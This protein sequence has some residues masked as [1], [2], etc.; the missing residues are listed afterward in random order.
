ML[1]MRHL[2]KDCVLRMGK[3]TDKMMA[4]R[5]TNNDRNA[6]RS[7]H[8]DRD[9]EDRQELAAMDMHDLRSVRRKFNRYTAY[10]ENQQK[11]FNWGKRAFSSTEDKEKEIRMYRKAHHEEMC[12]MK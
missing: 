12:K 2:A 4:M 10:T 6:V 5:T 11:K 7:D 9:W 8:D 1:D 3:R